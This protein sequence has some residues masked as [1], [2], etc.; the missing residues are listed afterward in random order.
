M[1]A[2]DTLWLAGEPSAPGWTRLGAH[3][4][5]GRELIDFDWFRMDLPHDVPP[6]SQMVVDTTLPSI[7]SPGDYTVTFDFVVEG[8]AWF[9]D[10]GSLTTRLKLQVT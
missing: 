2:G 3:L 4:H 7:D 5:R 6:G 1:N 8:I 10:R 9:A